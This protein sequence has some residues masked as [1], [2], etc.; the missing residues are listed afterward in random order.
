MCGRFLLFT[1]EEYEEIRLIIKEL[2]LSDNSLEQLK[3]GEIFPTNIVPAIISDSENKKTYKLF[4]W[5]FP[6]FKQLSSVIINARGETLE[7]KPTFRKLLLTKRCLIPACG[8]FE[9]KKSGNKKDKYLIKPERNNYFYFAG[10]YNTFRER[11]GEAYTS[12]VIITTEAN[13]EMKAIHNRMPLMI[14]STEEAEDWL[15]NKAPD[16]KR[17]KSIIIPFD[18]KI[19]LENQSNQLQFQ[20]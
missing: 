11:S 2:E 14:T 8:F 3:T 9:W 13:D 18:Q 15:N 19:Y 17:A 10:L 4:K 7:E 20:I 16:F 1:S 12:F 6:N 5:G